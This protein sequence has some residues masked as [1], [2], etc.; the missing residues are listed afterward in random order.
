MLTENEEYGAAEPLLRRALALQEKVDPK[1][2]LV[3]ADCLEA[4]ASLLNA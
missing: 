1:D 3:T 2:S 4:L